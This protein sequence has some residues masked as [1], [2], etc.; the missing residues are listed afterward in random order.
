[1][2]KLRIV[3]SALFSFEKTSIDGRAD[4]Q[5]PAQWDPRI[6]AGIAGHAYYSRTR[7]KNIWT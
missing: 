6:L 2:E 4:V 7:I 5:Q 3:R 1:M